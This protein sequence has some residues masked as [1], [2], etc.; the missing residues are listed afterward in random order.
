MT[1]INNLTVKN[2]VLTIIFKSSNIQTDKY[3][4]NSNTGICEKDKNGRKHAGATV[5]RLR[6]PSNA[7]TRQ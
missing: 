6:R 5:P 7:S 1:Q 2:N 4:C 3:S